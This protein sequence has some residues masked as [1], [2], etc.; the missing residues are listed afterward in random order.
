MTRLPTLWNDVRYSARSLSARP[1]FSLIA[2]LTL[3]LGIGV[4]VAIFSL[5]EQILL[6]PLPVAEPENLVNLS[7][8]VSGTYGFW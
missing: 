7:D 1:T 8:A 3:A 5:F 6:R 2:A 4:N